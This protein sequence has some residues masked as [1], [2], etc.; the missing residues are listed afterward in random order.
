MARNVRQEAAGQWSAAALG[1]VLV[2]LTAAVAVASRASVH[3]SSGS[4]GGGSGTAHALGAVVLSLGVVLIVA[5]VGVL[6]VALW[7]SA[8]RRKRGSEDDLYAPY[9][10]DMTGWEKAVLIGLL[11][12]VFGGAFG[13]VALIYTHHGGPAPVTITQGAAPGFG[14]ASGPSEST[15][16]A[17]ATGGSS[18]LGPALVAGIVLAIV[19]ALAALLFTRRPRPPADEAARER[20]RVARVV[21]WSLDDL[22]REPDPRRAV[23]AAYAR[24]E[25]MFAEQGMGR[26]AF[27]TPLEYLGRV[28]GHGHT[29]GASIGRL[30]GLFQRAKFSPHPIGNEER[31]EAVETLGAIREDLER[32]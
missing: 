16:T 22:R 6:V 5:V 3:G 11:A 13:V 20:H 17:P 14:G 30:T 29:N 1:A 21:E 32:E 25:R 8:L 27:E 7:P 24:M 10:P 18:Q 23:I 4:L 12:L 26:R 19:A 2:G 28:L 9:R 31:A 15:P